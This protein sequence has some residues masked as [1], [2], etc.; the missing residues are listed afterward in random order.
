MHSVHHVQYDHC[1][2]VADHVHCDFV[3]PIPL[4]RFD[5]D[6]NGLVLAYLTDNIPIFLVS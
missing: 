1:D 5:Y 6:D 2:A 3:R 4:N